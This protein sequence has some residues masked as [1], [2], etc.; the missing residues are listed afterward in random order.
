MRA[1]YFKL[2]WW[3]SFVWATM[4][5]Q[6]S[7]TQKHFPHINPTCQ[8]TWI[9]LFADLWL[10]IDNAQKGQ[11]VFISMLDFWCRQIVSFMS[12]WSSPNITWLLVSLERAFKGFPL[13]SMKTLATYF[14][15]G[16][17]TVPFKSPT[18]GMVWWYWHS[19]SCT[20]VFSRFVFR[21]RDKSWSEDWTICHSTVRATSM[22]QM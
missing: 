22:D 18:T 11:M 13:F 1:F 9:W 15:N 8:C 10:P 3:T 14:M 16:R 19:S 7:S 5:S 12:S 21:P 17:S 4:S 6:V 2:K 20:I